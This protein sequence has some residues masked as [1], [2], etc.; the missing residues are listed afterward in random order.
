M[1][2]LFKR[3]NDERL[4]KVSAQ[5]KKPSEEI[6]LPFS[7]GKISR[8]ELEPQQTFESGDLTSMLGS[9]TRRRYVKAEGG[10]AAKMPAMPACWTRSSTVFTSVE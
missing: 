1:E 8:M 5:G 7:L 9:K 3:V 4:R 6:F 10:Q 2:G